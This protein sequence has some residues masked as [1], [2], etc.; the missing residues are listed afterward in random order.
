M[1]E[2]TQNYRRDEIYRAR[3]DAVEDFVFD[4][5]VTEVFPDMIRRSVPGYE[6]IV[7]MIGVIVGQHLHA[8]DRIFDLGCSRG[9]IT[10][11]ILNVVGD[12]PC[13]IHAVDSSE[14]MINQAVADVQD[15][16][17]EFQCEDIRKTDVEDAQA[18]ILNLVLQF[19]PPEHRT[20]LIRRIFEGTNE[21][22][23]LVLTEK[24]QSTRNFEELHLRFKRSSG[25]SELEIEQ[26]RTALE[27]V[28]KLESL[29]QHF[30]RLR[31]VGYRRISTWFR[32]LNWVSV[33]A[34][35]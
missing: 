17:V 32:C 12:L 31:A 15:T 18:V 34:Y 2:P 8:E 25:Y 19:V 28:M 21:G 24:I 26:K 35:K 7:E 9:A 27:A 14:S 33:L 6:T 1:I 4:N 23:L 20:A 3:L 5:K 13:R 22:G 11:S 30:S 16:R 29:S 10:G